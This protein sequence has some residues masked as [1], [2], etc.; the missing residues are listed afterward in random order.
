MAPSTC[1]SGAATP[2]GGSPS[3]YNRILAAV[4]ARDR[5][6]ERQSLVMQLAA[7]VAKETSTETAVKELVDATYK[8]VDCE[9]VSLFLIEDGR[10][11]C[12]AAPAG[13]EVAWTISLGQG[14]AGRVASSGQTMNV[15]D[16]YNCIDIFDSTQDRLTHYKTNSILCMP[17]RDGTGEVIGVMQAINKKGV[18]VLGQHLAFDEVDEKLMDFLLA[19]TAQQIRLFELISEK[20]AATIRTDTAMQLIET[21]CRQPE[22]DEALLALAA[23]TKALMDCQRVFVF[24]KEQGSLVC[25]AAGRSG[26]SADVLGLRLDLG[27]RVVGAVS[28]A[29]R[30]MLFN[31]EDDLQDIVF[32]EEKLP[33]DCK[34]SFNAAD[35]DDEGSVWPSRVISALCSPLVA[36]ETGETFGVILALNRKRGLSQGGVEAA[37]SGSRGEA[38]PSKGSPS[39]SSALGTLLRRQCSFGL[40]GGSTQIDVAPFTG[41]DVQRLDTLLRLASQF[42]QVSLSSA[43]QLRTT[44]KL[45]ALLSLLSDAKAKLQDGDTR[46]F[47][48]L[49]LAKS[50][51]MFECDRCT[52]FTVDSLNG[53]LLGYY[54]ADGDDKLQE[55]RVP[56]QGIVGLVAST[57][58][59]LNIRDAWSDERFSN[60]TD[61][62]TGYRT[63]TLLCAPLASSTGKVIAVLQCINKLRCEYFGPDDENMLLTVSALLSDLI[64]RM[65]MESGYE[66]FVQKNDAIDTDVKDMFA[67]YHQGGALR[68]GAEVATRPATAAIGSAEDTANLVLRDFSRWDFVQDTLLEEPNKLHACLRGCFS[69]FGLLSA[70]CIPPASLDAWVQAMR[71][72]Y[73]QRAMY[74]NWSHAIGTLHA[75]FLLLTSW[76]FAGLLPDE[77]VLAL[78][79]AAIGHD[80]EHPGYTNTFLVNTRHQLAIRYNDISVLES[81]HASVTCTG[82]RPAAAGAAELGGR[83][84]R[85]PGDVT[86]ILG[87]DMA[88]HKET[89]TWLESNN[90]DLVGLRRSGLRLQNDDALELCTAMLHSADLVHPA[91]PWRIHKQRSLQVAAE[92]FSQFEEEQR[93]GLPTLPFMGKDPNHLGG[94]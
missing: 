41:G 75:T 36:T 26:G 14:I 25:R 93:L 27:D 66:S 58:K 50:L 8:V 65:V 91:L 4:A 3:A 10:L 67:Q 16:A 94:L 77:D 9:R 81:H 85:A 1:R 12:H 84:A 28:A 61:L 56:I 62:R 33:M 60:K 46:R 6:I 30:P 44:Q 79:F 70:F 47:A 31:L 55:L 29:G 87:T 68:S 13:G 42:V 49:I 21:I 35:C 11:V 48:S 45:E 34:D 78:L 43:R 54:H 90:S 57:N 51:A 38:S 89:I 17:I 37:R 86:S 5:I 92:F 20:E 63:R 7:Q 52:F 59:L 23:G 83:A 69:Y 18:D 15:A 74:H 2:V 39:R 73:S 72:R 22:L 19:M 53:E 80:V 40:N 24:L 88:K 64:Q 82:E 76:A 32:L 71:A